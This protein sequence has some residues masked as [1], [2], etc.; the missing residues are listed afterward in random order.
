MTNSKNNLP[1]KNADFLLPKK[2]IDLTKWAV[3][4]CDQHTSDLSYWQK[5]ETLVGNSKSTL[6]L[7]LPEAYLGNRNEE[8]HID[9]IKKAMGDYLATD[10]FNS[11]SGAVAIERK[12][13]N[14]KTRNGL[15][16]AIDLEHYDFN[17]SSKALIRA[18]EGTVLERIPP[19]VKVRQNCMLDMSHV[20]VL[21]DDPS[22]KVQ[23]AVTAAKSEPLYDFDLN[24]NGGHISGSLIK[25][26]TNIFNAFNELMASLGQN[27]SDKMLFAVGDGNHSLAAAKTVYENKKAIGEGE[28]SRYALV[29]AVN[30]YDDSLEFEPIHRLVLGS[31]LEKFKTELDK[32]MPANP[33]EA[34]EFVDKLAAKHNL[35]VDYIHGESHLK[36]LAESKKCL[37]IKLE[38][39]DKKGFFT[40]II[41][42]GALPKKTFSMGEAE[43]KRYYLE[44][45]KIV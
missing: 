37:A 13:S 27:S 10:M 30:I 25:D 32:N 31:G 16:L 33:I 40:Y 45:A 39:M 34:V 14:G 22:F 42:H 19:R 44:T 6:N 41:K 3:V 17:K 4:A 43:D 5:L 35:E 8:Q 38:P 18:S 36:S 21:Y 20:L 9:G 7:I 15:L 11:F 24:M 2:D 23:N 26:T 12:V 1:I 28:F 29:E